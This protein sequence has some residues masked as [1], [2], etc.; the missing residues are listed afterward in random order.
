MSDNA[1][2]FQP[3]KNHFGNR[4]ITDT[5]RLPD[6]SHD[7]S[8]IRIQPAAVFFAESEADVVEAVSICRENNLSIVFRGAG[9]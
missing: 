2:R 3:L 4:V 6:Y 7:A 5:H 8:E 9:T 1:S